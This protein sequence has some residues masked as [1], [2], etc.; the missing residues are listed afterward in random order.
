MRRRPTARR[1]SAC[2]SPGSWRRSSTASPRSATAALGLPAFALAW[3]LVVVCLRRRLQTLYR[4]W[5]PARISTAAARPDG[6]AACSVL[7]SSLW[8]AAPVAVVWQVPGPSA[9]GFLALA[10]G[11]LAATAG[12]VGWMSR[13]GLDRD[14]GSGG[15]AVLLIAWPGL[16]GLSA[17]ALAASLLSFAFACLLII[18]ATQRLIGGAVE[19]RTKSNV[20]MREL[21]LALAQSEAAEQQL[22]RARDEAEAA[23]RAKSQFLA[24]MSHEIR[25]PMNGVHGHERGSCCGPSSAAAAARARRDGC[26]VG[27]RACWRS[28]TT[29]STSRSSRPASSSSRS[30][31]SS[32]RTAGRGRAS[33]LLPPQA[34]EQGPGVRLQTSTPA[35]APPFKGDPTRLRQVLLNLVSTR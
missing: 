29:S 19:D 26:A 35:A 12:A 21:R 33:Q 17:L 34:D 16:M 6:L 15:A 27:R 8:L 22:F 32:L 5:L 11:T 10:V 28:S 14:R 13:G 2:S 31:T 30:S 20:A 1:W 3:G 7:R 4:R 18:L 24:N 25:T 9:Y 23:N